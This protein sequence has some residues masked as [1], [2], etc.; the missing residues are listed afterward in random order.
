M[1]GASQFVDQ[2][3]SLISPAPFSIPALGFSPQR[4]EMDCWTR[5]QHRTG[6]VPVL[7]PVGADLLEAVQFGQLVVYL[8]SC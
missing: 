1:G 7:F 5:S 2:S 6:P 3:T 8:L 4:E